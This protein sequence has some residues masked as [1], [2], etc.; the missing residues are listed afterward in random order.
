ME[1]L[2]NYLLSASFG[3]PKGRLVKINIRESGEPESTALLNEMPLER[4]REI[5]VKTFKWPAELVDKQIVEMENGY[6]YSCSLSMTIDGL[7]RSGLLTR[8]QSSEIA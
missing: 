3:F 2:P 8:H 7:H 1:D 4:F 5:L 6:G